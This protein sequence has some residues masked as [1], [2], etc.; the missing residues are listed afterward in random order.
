MRRGPIRRS[1]N[2]RWTTCPLRGNCGVLR[3]NATS[4]DGGDG[5]TGCNVRACREA[6]CDWDN[7]CCGEFGGWWDRLCVSYAGTLSVCCKS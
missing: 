5:Q 4:E 6:V 1:C 7:F 2:E 3:R